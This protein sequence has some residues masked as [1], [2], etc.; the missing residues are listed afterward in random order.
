MNKPRFDICLIVKNE[1]KTLPRLLISLEEFKKRGGQ[2]TILD[3]GS[4][5]NTVKLARDWG[6]VVEEVGEKY[7]HV[8]GKD[9]AYEINKRFI[10]ND[11]EPVIK[12]G[13][14]YFDFA[15]ARN[16]AASLASTDMVSFA[17]ADEEFTKLDIDII[18]KL[19]DDGVEQFE[20]N[21]VFSH[22]QFGNEAFKFIQ[23]KFH[24]RR[25]MKWVGIVHEVLQGSAKRHMLNE[26]ILKLEHWQNHDT[27]RHV[28]L[29]GLAVDCYEN[30]DKDR[31]SHYFAR[32]LMWAGRPKSAM[33]EFK[34]H[35]KMDRWPAEKAQSMIFMGDCHGMIGEPEKQV[36]WYNKAFYHDSTR[37]E[38]LI[39]LARF[40]QHN[41]NHE[42]AAAYA[43]ASLEIPW[44]GFYANNKENYTTDPH[45][46]LYWAKGWMGDVEGAKEHLLKAMSY[47]PHN[48]AYLRDTKFYF[49][50]PDQGIDGWMTFIELNWLYNMGKKYKD[51]AEVGSWKGRSTHAL[52][53]SGIDVTAVDTW[54][55][56]DFEKDDT[57][58]LAKIQDVFKQF[59][60]NTKGF[61]NLKIH[62]AR[63]LDAAKDYPDG[64][65]DVV[66]I[67]AGHT[68]EDVKRDIAAWKSKAKKMLCGHDYLQD[69]WMGVIQAVDEAF[70]KPDGV[71]GSIWW[72]DL[73]KRREEIPARIFSIWLGDEMPDTIKKCVETH[74]IPGYEHRMITMDNYPKDIPYVNAAIK[75]KKWVK[76]V[77]YLK[78]YYLYNEGGIYLDT[79]VEILPG[80][81]YDD[82]LNNNV[83]AAREENG[84]IGFS[85]VGGIK[86][87]EIFK[88]YLD[89]VPKK[90]K[91]DD[92]KNFESS[93]EVFTELADKFSDVRIYSPDYFFPYN[94]QTGII[95]VTENTRSFHHF[96][97]S[98]TDVTDL[99][100]KVS[101]VLPTLGR[102][103]GLKRCLKS[104]D[105]LYYPKHL[106]E[107]IVL[108]GEEGTVPE[109]VKKGVG[110][111]DGEYIVYASNDIEFEPYS[112]YR[113]V[114]TSLDS[115]KGLVAFDTGV[116][117]EEGFIN[118]HF[119]FRLDLLDKIGGEVFDTDF[120]H[121]GIDDLLWKKC[122]KL[123]EAMM[124]KGK[125]KHYHFSRLDED[126]PKD[127]VIERGW[128][129]E[130]ED[131][132]LLV[133]KLQELEK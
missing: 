131:R 38:S 95:N 7:I 94:H 5:D 77:D 42:A 57:S 10:I 118:E 47:S 121:V 106:I 72:I 12:A 81:N 24:D 109:K 98:W 58:R 88:R 8:I 107:L 9:L 99:L 83:F 61:D 120:H 27:S 4:T 67:D 129:K 85:L 73:E 89:E 53:S 104:I 50:Y 3:T 16:H 36:V 100:P 123:G 35:I 64:A 21:F 91:G 126:T 84:F 20:Y 15:S 63:S 32:E 62:K 33:N 116:K 82:M 117:N 79:D 51:I 68:Y 11:E 130:K 40:Y 41:N 34:R 80:K 43:A 119:L 127:W 105:R 96:L 2:T 115:K 112:L 69:V 70:G 133:K 17:D 25:K 110:K 46:I 37:R 60:D 44:S 102:E 26:S 71:E 56:S 49:E 52:L 101:I 14:K 23:S 108:D 111:A 59:K 45:E 97:K 78:M 75:A 54:E 39:K 22:D 1:E 19:I 30:Q 93:M 103:D 86:G 113:A 114:K 124:S 128:A 76:A 29:V 55:G 122:D 13:D 92:D 132:E 31:N 6:C 18:D 65:F 87:H 90:F 48:P 28:Y 125:V 66:F 74:K